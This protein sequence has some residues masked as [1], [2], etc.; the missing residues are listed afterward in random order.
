MGPLPP[1]LHQLEDQTYWFVQD[2]ASVRTVPH[3]QARKPR[4]ER[5]GRTAL[6]I[7][8]GQGQRW[9]H[10]RWGRPAPPCPGPPPVFSWGFWPGFVCRRQ[11]PWPGQP[12]FHP[13]P[14][15]PT[16]ESAGFPQP[17]MADF[18][19]TFPEAEVNQPSQP[20][21]SIFSLGG[22]ERIQVLLSSAL[23]RCLLPHTGPG[24]PFRSRVRPQPEAFQSDLAPP[25]LR[26]PIHPSSIVF[27]VGFCAA[28]GSP[29]VKRA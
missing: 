28:P 7:P 11:A 5:L 9:S 24:R 18:R 10:S 6:R 25:A 4:A 27:G 19:M 20:P 8:A 16:V 21:L 12:G 1:H 26:L 2:H 23:H 15:L 29:A 13:A 3:F 22:R 14:L 17:T